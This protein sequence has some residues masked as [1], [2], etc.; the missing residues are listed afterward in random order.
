MCPLCG[1]PSPCPHFSK[2][3]STQHHEF[4]VA[5]GK[6]PFGAMIRAHASK[7]RRNPTPSEALFEDTWRCWYPKIKLE[8]QVIVG[9][10]IMDFYVPDYHVGIEIDGH[11]HEL[12]RVKDWERT[13][14]IKRLAGIKIVRFTNQQI[15]NCPWKAFNHLYQVFESSKQTSA[16]AEFSPGFTPSPTDRLPIENDGAL[17]G[18]GDAGKAH[19]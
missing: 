13:Q 6:A 17:S 19:N 7:M 1:K 14:E 5:K 15:K 4:K 12:Q 9:P 8:S 3:F 10:Y 2:G 16:L 18:S 11:M